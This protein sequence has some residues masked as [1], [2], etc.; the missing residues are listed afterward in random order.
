MGTALEFHQQRGTIVHQ[1]PRLRI[2]HSLR[3]KINSKINKTNKMNNEKI[4]VKFIYLPLINFALQQN[5]VPLI[6]VFA[7][8]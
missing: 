4:N 1:Q 5:R 3:I 8:F 6:R 7:I 2:S